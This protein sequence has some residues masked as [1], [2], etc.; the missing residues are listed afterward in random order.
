MGSLGATRGGRS[1]GLSA[2]PDRLSDQADSLRRVEGPDG[3]EVI[4]C[5]D[6]SEW[7]SWLAEN[8]EDTPGAWLKIAKKHPG[9]TTVPIG[10]ALDVALCHGWIDSIRRSHDGAYYLQ[11]YSP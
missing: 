2:Q 6:A 9:Q 11:R 3:I 5:K 1:T 10:E 7:E 8:H 4:V